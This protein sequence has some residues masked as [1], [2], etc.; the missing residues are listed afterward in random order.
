MKKRTNF[1]FLLLFFTATFFSAKSIKAIEISTDD[2]I[3]YMKENN[4]LEDADNFYMFGKMLNGNEE[5]NITNFKYNITKSADKI[6]IEVELTD[7]E[8]GKI[9]KTTSLTLQNNIIS[10]TNANDKDSLESR[11]DTVIFSQLIYSIGGARGYNKDILI[12]WM[13]QID[14]NTV[15]LEEGIECEFQN[16]RYSYEESD[17]IYDYEVSVPMSYR[18]DINK[19]TDNIPKI[20]TVEIKNV[21][22]KTS[23]ISMKIYS[24]NNLDK[25]CLIYR[26][27]E[28]DEYEQ[29]AKVSC[30]NGKYVD[31]RLKEGKDYYYQ[32]IVEDKIMCSPETKITTSTTPPLTGAFINAGKLLLT[33]LIVMFLY[34]IIKKKEIFKRI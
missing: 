14:L 31:K 3:S 13:N 4:I 8:E 11:I 27:N 15:T 1:L 22:I 17:R 28:D 10:Y 20:D 19:I 30:N 18:V 12:N 23:S 16:V 7:A 9:E 5:Y 6:D 34:Y 21:E 2:V 25:E 26:K 29:I 24:E 33:A 32:V